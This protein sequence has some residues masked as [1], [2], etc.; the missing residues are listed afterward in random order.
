MFTRTTSAKSDMD[1]MQIKEN[2]KQHEALKIIFET[3]LVLALSVGCWFTL[4]S[5]FPNPINHEVSI[6]AI[7]C[8]PVIFYFINRFLKIGRYLIFY[9]FIAVALFFVLMYRNVW[10]GFL[11]FL[12]IVVEILNE[13]LALGMVGFE[14][15][16][17]ASSWSLDVL[18]AFIPVIILISASIAYSV[19]FKEVVLGLSITA[20]PVIAGLALKAVPST[21]LLALLFLAWTGLMVLTAVEKPVSKK[22]N[23]PI[24]IQNE[25]QSPLPLLFLTITLVLLL[26][27]I[28]LFS[29]KSYNPPKK[30]DE[31][32]DKIIEVEEH[33]RY[34]KLSGA[35]IEMLPQGD[36][37]KI[38]PLIYTDNIV[39]NLKMDVAKPMYLRGF[40]GG[41]YENGKWSSSEDWA[42]S[43][44]YK[45]LSQ[46]LAQQNFY[47]WCQLDNV[48]RMSEDYDLN[49]VKI[50]NINASSKYIYAPYEAAV[51]KDLTPDKVNYFR[52]AGLLSR[53][54][55]GD[56]EYSFTAFVPEFDEYDGIK[57]RRWL[58]KLREKDGFEEYLEKEGVYRRFVYDTYLY[59]SD[60]ADKAL[61]DQEKKLE[62]N[63][64]KDLDSIVFSVR[65]LLADKYTYDLETAGS[66]EGT[67]EL[68][69]FL[70]SSFKGNDL[71]FAT[72]ATLMFRKSGIP[73]RYAEGYYISPERAKTYSG[74][75]NTTVE[76]PD[77]YGHSWVEIY[78][79]ELGWTP[80]E[81]IPGFYDINKTETE[82]EVPDEEIKQENEDFKK[83]ESPIEDE[84][85]QTHTKE[86]EISPLWYV[87]A[88]LLFLVLLVL[89]FE[90][91]GKYRMKRIKAT[92]GTIFTE[93]QVYDMYKYIVKVMKFDG[94]RLSANPLDRNAE[95]SKRYDTDT[96]IKFEQVIVRVSSVRFGH[97][98]WNEDTHKDI[99]LYTE[100]L[101]DAVYNKQ[102]KFKKFLMKFVFFY[103]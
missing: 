27:Y 60:D 13:Q 15:T 56:R 29:D 21:W 67:D 82:E 24:Y 44:E 69:Y 77:S 39:M 61:S 22:R 70:K 32:K 84:Q 48:Y 102:T 3:I 45:G 41:F 17:N 93:K 85:E 58:S 80:V 6:A 63:I 97:K 28:L 87:L 100:R 83:S 14:T 25:K 98:V 73:A 40:T 37:T 38:H 72:A 43:T 18:F 75:D 19:F 36:L 49:N 68:S 88:G 23:K 65:T 76:I 81:V 79:D 101:T 66:S 91:M 42:F 57:I 12:N 90:L 54:F 46:W 9:V 53:G 1:L 52:D 92:F 33:L 16:G 95:I 103:V 5:M 7:T 20:L 35:E 71:H 86:K 4:F 64:G 47:T 78:V 59:V 26:M 51:T 55:F 62:K 10:N 31:I 34:D 99:A 89:L 8:M 94:I 11:V 96:N 2:P 50:E 30:V 74:L